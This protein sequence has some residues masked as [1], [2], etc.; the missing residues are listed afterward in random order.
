MSMQLPPREYNF[1]DMVRILSTI[2]T[3]LANLERALTDRSYEMTT[4]D[5]RTLD[6]A[7][8]TTADVA[9]VVGTL[10]KDL[11]ARGRLP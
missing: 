4:T 7:T 1:S 11:Q 2:D 10:V 6:E 9:N 5:L 3:R 8:A